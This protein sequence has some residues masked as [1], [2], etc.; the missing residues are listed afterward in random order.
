MT[1]EINTEDLKL[2]DTVKVVRYI[3]GLGTKYHLYTGEKGIVISCNKRGVGVRLFKQLKT[4]WFENNKQYDEKLELIK[5]GTGEQPVGGVDYPLSEAE[6]LEIEI[7]ALR[8]KVANHDARHMGYTNPATYLA[9]L[10]LNNSAE[11]MLVTRKK[12][13]RKNGTLNP[14][15]VEKEFKKLG[16]QIDDWAYE[17]P[18]DIPE[19]FKDCHF[20]WDKN[21]KWAEVAKE[22]AL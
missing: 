21:I 1:T 10:Y 3:V 22:F 7:A 5:Q 17:T 9:W 20:A 16:L 6:K 2:G 4:V 8:L 12:L 15:R 18:I 14:S 19:K 11:F 13:A